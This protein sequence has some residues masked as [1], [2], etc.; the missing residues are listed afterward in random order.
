MRDVVRR[1]TTRYCG[2]N[3][4]NNIWITGN[5]LKTATEIK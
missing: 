1:K 3:K 5:K 2:L 4:L